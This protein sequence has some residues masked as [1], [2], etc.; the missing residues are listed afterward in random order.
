M[1]PGR[2]GMANR[3]SVLAGFATVTTCIEHRASEHD[4]RVGGNRYRL[5]KTNPDSSVIKV[6][7]A[8]YTV[9]NVVAVFHDA[10]ERVTATTPLKERHDP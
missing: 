10:L 9:Q 2:L 4:K 5:L 6:K 7:T 8:Y 3:L 1:H